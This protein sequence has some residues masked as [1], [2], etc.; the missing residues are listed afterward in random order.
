VLAGSSI[1]TFPDA[2]TTG[3]NNHGFALQALGC[4]V[5]LLWQ[6]VHT[7]TWINLLSRKTWQGRCADSAS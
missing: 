4:G 5:G 6:Q 7:L 3:R 1:G 2:K